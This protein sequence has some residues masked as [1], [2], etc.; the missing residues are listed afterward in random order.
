MPRVARQI[1]VAHA[2]GL[3][4]RPAA[5]FVQLAKRF[6]SRITVARGRRSADGK[7]IME[8]LTLAVASGSEI[9]IVADGPDAQEAVDRLC[10]FVSRP[11]VE[12]AHGS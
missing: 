12:P 10:H 3:H 11:L 9:R 8:L 4:A 6:N 5:L 2:Q 7:S 1:L